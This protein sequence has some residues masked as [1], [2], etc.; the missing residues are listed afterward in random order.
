MAEDERIK[1]R[2]EVAQRHYDVEIARNTEVYYRKAEKIINDTILQFS[3]LWTY[4][5]HQDILAI[6]FFFFL[7]EHKNQMLINF[8]HKLVIFLYLQ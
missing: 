2:L 3:K 6:F 1:I 5:D 7:L 4:N 8:V